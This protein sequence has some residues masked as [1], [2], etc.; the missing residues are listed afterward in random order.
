MDL[1]THIHSPWTVCRVSGDIDTSTAHALR[2]HLVAALDR[3]GHQT[4]LDLSAVTFMDASG[5]G[6]LVSIEN[7][8]LRQ[9]WTLRLHAPPL[10]IRRLLTIT[11]LSD[12]F[13]INLDLASARQ[14]DR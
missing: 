12:H 1:S 5:L 9:G 14:P 10:A 6:V 7:L 3:P 8:A 13:A 4:L 2:E 11:G